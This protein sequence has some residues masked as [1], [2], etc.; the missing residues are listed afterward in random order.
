MMERILLLDL[1]YH[2][3]R[4]I[5]VKALS[6]LRD[7]YGRKTGGVFGLL[8]TIQLCLARCQ[9]CEKV[10][11]VW[12]GGRSARRLSLFPPDLE[13]QVGYKANRGILP[14]MT[15]EE[16]KE[17]EETLHTL[18]QSKELANPLLL[19]SGVHVIEW[20]DREADDVIALLARTLT[21][22]KA[23][24]KQA[25]I[26]SDDW[27]FA[28]CC[29]ETVCVFRAGQDEWL[30]LHNFM[31]KVK[32]PVD[33]S[34]TL[35]SVEGDTG[36]NIPGVDGVGP[37][38]FAK[39]VKAYLEQTKEGFDESWYDAHQYRDTK[40][41]DLTPF[42]DFCA[43]DKRKRMKAIGN[44]RDLI[45]RNAELIDLTREHFPPEHVEMLLSG[46][47]SPRQFEEM[48]VVKQLGELN[49]NSLLEN[50]AHWSDPF[51]RIS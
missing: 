11:G 47:L 33:W 36:D 6:E 27:D 24:A 26:A 17:K 38:W 10:I 48:T 15:E 20:P 39:A 2:L 32:V 25:V 4:C 22:D 21:S 14:G 34:A 46:V 42:F 43:A 31:E 50:F 51:R 7:Q 8:N 30:S 40:P 13:K 12:D 19:N 37:V 5:H 9:P 35:K 28:Q 49:V 18:M 1:N 44:N 3:R 29:S 41:D 16:R 23:V 45:L